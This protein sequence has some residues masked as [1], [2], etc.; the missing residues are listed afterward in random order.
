MVLTLK[1][2]KGG[3]GKDL[4]VCPGLGGKTGGLLL[5]KGC[6]IKEILVGRGQFYEEKNR[7]SRGNEKKHFGPFLN[8]DLRA[9]WS[10]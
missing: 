3:P 4:L 10:F 7:D 6:H 1:A 5:K 2:Q 8:S 9:R